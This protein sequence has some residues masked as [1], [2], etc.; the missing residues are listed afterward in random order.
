MNL[1][2]LVLAYLGIGFLIAAVKFL[3]AFQQGTDL[4]GPMGFLTE[5]VIWPAWVFGLVIGFFS[6]LYR[7]F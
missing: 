7:P 3:G 5:V 6:K 2:K 1:G 4:G